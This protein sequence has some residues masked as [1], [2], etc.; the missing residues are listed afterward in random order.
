MISG[1][2]I[3]R[4]KIPTCFR[5][6]I[7]ARQAMLRQND[8]FPIPG[9]P[10]HAVEFGETG[11][12]ADDEPLVPGGIFDFL[13]RGIGEFARRLE[14]ALD[15]PRRNLEDPGLGFLQDLRRTLL[16]FVAPAH[17]LVRELDQLPCGGFLPDGFRVVADIQPAGESIRQ[18]GQ[19]CCPAGGFFLV[20]A[21]K[22]L[23]QRDEVDGRLFID[24]PE[25]RP[26]YLAVSLKI[27][28]L[29]HQDFGRRED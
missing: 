21:A 5:S 11:I 13:V 17:Q 22:F 4:L 12:D 18:G 1:F 29:D 20:P 3:S 8:V 10:G 6:L 15:F 25:H 2:D 27:E 14:T 26:E 7:A 24:Q 9:L 19:V 23:P 28:V 16:P